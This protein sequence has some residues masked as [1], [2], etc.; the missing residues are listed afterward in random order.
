MGATRFQPASRERERAMKGL[1]AAAAIG[2]VA[3]GWSSAANAQ[4]WVFC[5]Y[6]HGFCSAPYGA[7]I[8]YGLNG[9][10]AHRRSPPGGLPCDNATFGDPLLGAHKRCF[11]SY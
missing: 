3:L 11:V 9:V 6:E 10:F 1:I 4:G 2:A 8:H 7:M 5:A